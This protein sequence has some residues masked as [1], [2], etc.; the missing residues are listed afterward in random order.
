VKTFYFLA[1][2]QTLSLIG[3]R[4]TSIALG[5]YLF[6][7]TGKTS[8]L[9]LAAFFNELPGMLFG[10]L[11]GV[12]VDRWDR[13][14]VLVLADAGQ[15]MGTLLLLASF[16]SGRFQVWHLYLV[17][18]FQGVF[19][20]FQ[21]PAKD[22]VTTLLV[23]EGQRER[24]NGVLQ[25]VF[26]LAGV[27][28]PVLAGALYLLIGLQGV[29]AADLITFLL[30]AAAVFLVRIPRPKPSAEAQAMRG[31]LWKELAGALGFLRSRRALLDM[32]IYNTLINYLLN[33]PL[34]LAIPFLILRTGSQAQMGVL[35]GVFSLGALAGGG[36]IAIW[37]GTRPRIHTLLPGM[38][39]TGAMFLVYGTARHPLLLG[40]AL[41][42]L[43][44]PLP[45]G[46]AL[47]AS[48]LQVKVPPDLQGRVF[49]IQGQLSFVGSTLSF[50]TIGQLV[51]YV[52][53]PAVGRPG[54]QAVAPL[55]GSQPGSGMGLLLGV[56]G[57]VILAATAFV[58]LVPSIRRLEALLPDYEALV[59]G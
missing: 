48:I 23:P 4:M 51:D 22:A 26:P 17:V 54:W 32:L 44:A 29:I 55:V 10:S 56:T 27:V 49:A 13:R 34:E 16:V 11:A 57:L 59:D 5:I 35:M 45:A 37:G 38:L 46:G 31:S 52:L 36:L 47:F 15:A 2:T 39:L 30:A 18:L 20:V 50:L 43:V 6:T 41:F 28:A 58:Y 3:S 42:L 14:R 21:G 1:I 53:E 9:L 7:T 40:I 25:M 33:G 12:I 8:P 24:A 19:A